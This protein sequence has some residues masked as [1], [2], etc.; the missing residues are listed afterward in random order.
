[1]CEQLNG[2]SFYIT[3]LVTNLLENVPTKLVI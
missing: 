1:M 3:I 2:K